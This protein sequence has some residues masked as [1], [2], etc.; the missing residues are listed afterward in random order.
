ME[1]PSISM[2]EG[3]YRIPKQA[4]TSVNIV[5]TYSIGEVRR[6][7]SVEIIQEVIKQ[8]IQAIMVV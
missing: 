1:G 4:H 3:G 5:L 8:E 6:S 2:G 7:Q